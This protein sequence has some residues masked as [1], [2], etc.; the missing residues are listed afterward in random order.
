[1]EALTS[2]GPA[3]VRHLLLVEMLRE[4]RGAGDPKFVGPA[5]ALLNL[6][7]LAFFERYLAGETSAEIL[8]LLIFLEVVLFAVLA[9]TRF[10]TVTEETLRRGAIFPTSAWERFFFSAISNLRRPVVALW[11]GSVVVGFVTLGHSSWVEAIVPSLLFTLLILC[12][13]A[14][15]SLLLLTAAKRDGGGGVIVWGLLASVSCVAIAAL[16]MGEQSLVRFVVPVQWVAEA[17]RATREGNVALSL[18][19]L[20]L[21]LGLMGGGILAARRLC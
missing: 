10:L 1:M 8:A 5:L 9:L 15:M 14:G 16:L 12:T 11:L 17:I 3:A 19:A 4:R 20:A 6:F 7:F 21:L 18:R 13:Q 2:S